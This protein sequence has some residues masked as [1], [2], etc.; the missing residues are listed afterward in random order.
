MP[1]EYAGYCYG[2]QKREYTGSTKYG[3]W[4]LKNGKKLAYHQ[5]SV[6]NYAQKFL[7][8]TINDPRYQTFTREY[9]RRAREFK[10][11]DCI[12]VMAILSY[13]NITVI[14]W[15]IPRQRGGSHN[16]YINIM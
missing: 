13:E 14:C 7:H 1:E 12:I 16:Q 4:H 3:L 8:V 9:L 2:K 10:Y 6:A 5:H 15:L 11:Y